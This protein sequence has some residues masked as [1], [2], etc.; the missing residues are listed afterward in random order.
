MILVTINAAENKKLTEKIGKE[1]KSFFT[2]TDSFINICIQYK[3][4]IKKYDIDYANFYL[5]EPKA[6]IKTEEKI[7]AD[8]SCYCVENNKLIGIK[9]SDD[10][11]ED[12]SIKNKISLLE[13]I[14][15]NYCIIPF[16]IKNIIDI[17]NLDK[18]DEI[19]IHTLFQEKDQIKNIKMYNSR[20]MIKKFIIEQNGDVYEKIK[21]DEKKYIGNAL[22]DNIVKLIL[23]NINIDAETV[24]EEIKLCDR[25]DDY[26]NDNFPIPFVF[27]DNNKSQQEIIDYKIKLFEAVKNLSPTDYIYL[28]PAIIDILIKNAY[29]PLEEIKKAFRVV[30]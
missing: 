12:E 18:M 23:T 19:F 20:S 3:D 30:E 1:I 16:R 4:E 17:K 5:L 29:L 14:G 13:M 26:L 15:A 24:K 28:P 7:L 22:N 21:K 2:T 11:R 27:I 8:F 6:I 9:L 10:E 25:Y